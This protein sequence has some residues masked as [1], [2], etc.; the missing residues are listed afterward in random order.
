MSP[1][2]SL[3]LQLP[4][5]LPPFPRESNWQSFLKLH[6]RWRCDFLN[7]KWNPFQ[8]KQCEYEGLSARDKVELL[9]KL[10]HWRLELDD[11]GDLC[12]VSGR[13]ALWKAW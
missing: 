13:Q 4:H 8:V 1:L 6:V 7:E 3:S 10:C 12:R 9:H 2:A 11:V 5:A